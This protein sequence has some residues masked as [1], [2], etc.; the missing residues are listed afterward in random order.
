[1]RNLFLALIPAFLSYSAFSQGIADV[2]IEPNNPAINQPIKI[3][4][5][6]NHYARAL[7]HGAHP[8]FQR[9]S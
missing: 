1:M 2:S 7:V 3:V 8:L 9:C 5:K 6:N 4:I